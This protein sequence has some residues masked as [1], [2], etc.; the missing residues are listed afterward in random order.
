M[1]FLSVMNLVLL[2]VAPGMSDMTTE[3]FAALVN[4]PVELILEDGRR[5][6]GVLS[7]K[8]SDE[9]V[10]LETNLPDI[11]IESR[12][13]GR[14]VREMQ[15]V[16]G[17]RAPLDEPRDIA[18]PPAPIEEFPYPVEAPFPPAGELPPMPSIPTCAPQL[19][20]LHGFVPLFPAVDRLQAPRSLDVITTVANWDADS[21][22]DGLLLH[23][24]PR[25]AWGAM[26]AV[27]GHL[28]VQL[29]TETRFATGGRT[30]SRNDSFRIA[31][32]WSVP[33]QAIDFDA[34]GVIAKLPFRRIRPQRDFDIAP[35]ALLVARLRVPTA[36][37]F[38]ASDPNVV[39]RRGSRLR[40]DAFLIQ[41]HH[42]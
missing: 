33:V 8:S 32:R 39:L 16:T 38:E 28:D 34:D 5:P 31:E 20:P 41:H 25:D 18:I 11:A 24:Q 10:V 40:D 29:V 23:V 17:P 15:P 14:S 9:W 4:Q 27:D 2:I 3:K 37:T 26:V 13:A 12:F 19:C 6:R 30:V 1:P 42:R 22:L 7:P 36:G 21:E 35:D